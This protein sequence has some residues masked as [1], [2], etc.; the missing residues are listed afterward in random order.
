MK[1]GSGSAV[2][3]SA[4]DAKLTLAQPFTHSLL[5]AAASSC[6]LIREAPCLLDVPITVRSL[7]PLERLKELKRLPV[8]SE[9]LQAEGQ[10]GGL[11]GARVARSV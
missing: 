10:T 5:A 3:R 7:S 8:P 6:E 4:N 9:C 1:V 11:F 2:Y